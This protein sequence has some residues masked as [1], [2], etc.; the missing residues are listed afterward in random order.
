MNPDES[1]KEEPQVQ[2]TEENWKFLCVK[3]MSE[4]NQ[5][6]KRIANSLEK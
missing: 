1:K 5:N 4:I 6:L 2:I 3:L